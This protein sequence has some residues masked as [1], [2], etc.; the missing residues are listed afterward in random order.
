MRFPAGLYKSLALSFIKNR[1]K[2]GK[3]FP[4]VLMLEPTHLCNLACSGC[5]RI[6][7]NA[8]THARDLSLDECIDA[9]VQSGAPVV[10]VTGGEPLLYGQVVHS[11]KNCFACG[12]TS[13]FAPMVFWPGRWWMSFVRIQA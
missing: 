2:G 4:L 11:L 6:R 1:L 13:I 10:T 9:A 12:D 8:E 5:D 7:L 3:R